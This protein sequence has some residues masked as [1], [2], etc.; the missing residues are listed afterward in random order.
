MLHFNFDTNELECA[1]VYPHPHEVRAG[2]WL[3]VLSSCVV[4]VRS[5]HV[6]LGSHSRGNAEQHTLPGVVRACAQ[7]KALRAAVVGHGSLLFWAAA[8]AGVEL[9]GQPSRSGDFLYV[10]P[11]TGACGQRRAPPHRRVGPVS[12]PFCSAS[13][14][15][16]GVGWFVRVCMHACACMRACACV[17]VRA[18]VRVPIYFCD[19]HVCTHGYAHVSCAQTHAQTCTHA[20]NPF[21]G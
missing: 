18:R 12:R 15:I 10:P 3:G 2:V 21:H 7:I 20:H 13:T 1:Q 16:A 17:G 9:G 14:R 6:G 19:T 4:R 5:D 11:G 8:G